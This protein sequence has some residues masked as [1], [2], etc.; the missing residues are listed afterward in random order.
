[1]E[2]LNIFYSDLNKEAQQAVLDFWGLHSAEEG[3]LDIDIV[4]LFTLET[5]DE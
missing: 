3:N 5:N 2:T 4:P 1:M